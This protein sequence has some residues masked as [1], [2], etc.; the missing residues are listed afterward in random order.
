MCRLSW[1]RWIRVRHGGTSRHAGVLASVNLCGDQAG[2]LSLG[3]GSVGS[4]RNASALAF[5]RAP[6]T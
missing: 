4:R 2:C 3:D 6:G 5:R 1:K